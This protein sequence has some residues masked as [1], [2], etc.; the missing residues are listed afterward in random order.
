MLFTLLVLE[1][2]GMKEIVFDLFC[3]TFGCEKGIEVCTLHCYR[4][5]ARAFTAPPYL[6]LSLSVCLSL[7]LSLSLSLSLPVSLLG[8]TVNINTYYN[9]QQGP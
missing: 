1:L 2:F 9:V 7:L 8:S 6:S 5:R 3:C 4:L